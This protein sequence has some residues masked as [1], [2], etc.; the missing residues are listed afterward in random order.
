MHT[1]PTQPQRRAIEAPLGPVLVVAG[2][3]AGKTFALIKRIAHLVTS[4]NME[5]RRI[6]AVTFTN[7]AAEEI[8]QRL[9]EEPGGFAEAVCR[10]TI[11][12]FCASILREFPEQAGLKAGF[13][14]ADEDYQ[15]VL[16]RQLG[17]GRRAGQL[18]GLFSRRKL[19]GRRLTPGDEHILQQYRA[20]LRK[21]N[22]VDFDDL[23]VLTRRLLE[24]RGDL[25][26]AVA[27]RWLYVLVDEFQDVNEAQYAVL[28]RLA[29]LHRNIFAVGDDEQSIF[30]WA[31]A[32][33]RILERFQRDFD[34]DSPIVLDRNHRSSQQIFAAAR[35]L[36]AENPSL[37]EKDLAAHR[38]STHP[39]RAVSFPDDQSEMQWILDDIKADRAEAPD[40]RPGDYAILYR[41][42][43]IGERLEAFL[44]RHGVQCRL[45]KGR[46]L[47]EDPVIG[48]AIAALGL[49]LRPGDSAAAET[50]AQRV[51][52]EMLRHRIEAE[53]GSARDGDYLRAARRVAEGMPRG[54][55]DAKKLWRLIYQAEN[56][57]TMRERHATL[58]GLVQ[59]LL[60]T[61]VGPYHGAL[62]EHYQDLA[63]PTV[64][65]AARALARRL[66]AAREGG[67][68]VVLEPMNGLEIALR[69]MLFGAGF[70]LCRYAYE[71]DQTELDD[72]MIGPADSGPEGLA[73]TLFK[74]LQLLHAEGVAGALREFVSFDIETTDLDPLSCE[75]V[76]IAAVRVGDG[77]ISAEFHSLVRPNRPVSPRA[78]DVHG[79]SD[80]DLEGAPPFA[81]VWQ[82]FR[83]FCGGRTLVAHNGRRFDVPV[84]ERMAAGIGR[85]ERL[86]VFDTLPLARSLSGDS[87]R[88]QDLAARFGVATGRAHH[89]LDDARTLAA[90]YQALESLRAER[91]RKS[92][93]AGILPHF[94]L[95]LALDVSRADTDEVRLLFSIAR[96]HALS[97]FSDAL[98]FY[99]RERERLGAR[100][101]SPEEIVGRL[102]G[103]RLMDRLRQEIDPSERYPNAVA[104]LDALMD[105]AQGEP[106]EAAMIRFLERAALSVSHGAEP[107][108]HRVNLLTLHSTKGLEFSR[109][110]IVG[111]EDEQLPGWTSPDE[112]R[113]AAVQEARRLLYVGMTRARER[114]I[115]TRVD[116]RNDRPAGGS[117]FLAEMGIAPERPR[118]A[119][120][121]PARG[122]R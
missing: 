112:D 101:P 38:L 5:A 121:V 3:G 86:H 30:S 67:S 50:F 57:S 14:I 60:S 113:T 99:E 63:D 24:E 2:P 59:E 33:A 87:S 118:E 107:D 62:E 7:K 10:R 65:P 75:P 48:Y 122:E 102:G 71:V 23:V 27:S 45:A 116:R 100:G 117:Q 35:R 108:P 9:A 55:P 16:L 51:L 83:D 68:R 82:R 42:H 106:L 54:D 93:L 29:A 84:L 69:G 70:R 26:E 21:R 25:A 80:A 92:A 11:H 41:R 12:A 31:G 37:F 96:I 74:A 4:R 13:G 97:R 81:E 20:A 85:P 18:L 8:A 34:V 78:R 49:V 52:P 43:E 90:V 15:R 98:E 17:H 120:A 56:F 76:E 104:R 77:V 40:L 89:A 110:Y 1:V 119:D 61:R 114:L 64:L 105:Q 32:D 79:Y 95:A 72:V 6:L 46:P 111:V 115:M 91:A 73:Y 58:R 19:A 22:M 36:L 66:R 88:L 53:L 94:G 109:V 39:V 28:K 103:R 47:T 44:V